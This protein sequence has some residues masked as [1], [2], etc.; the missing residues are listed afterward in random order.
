MRVGIEVGGTFTDLVAVDGESVR[1]AKVPS[2]PASPDEGA[3]Q[4]IDAAGIDPGAID[5][6]VHGSTV[7]TNAVLERKG[8]AVCLFVTKGIRD[9]LLLQRHDKDAIYDLRYAKPEPVVRR[10]DV[11]EIDERIAADGTVVASPD[12]AAVTRLVRRVLAEGSYE[13]AA[14]CFLHAYANPDHERMVAGVIREIAPSLPVTCSNEV[15]REFREYER[16]ST[17]ALAAYV[18]PVMAGYVN[19][20]SAA[21]GRRGFAGRFSIM[22]SNGGRM[23]AEAMARNAISALFSGPAAGVV[24]AVRSVADA[25]YRNLITLDMG[26]TSTDVALVAD[27]RT[28]ARVDDANRRPA[29][30]DP[31]R[32]H[33]HRRGRR[34]L[35]RVGRRRRP[36]QGRPGL[37]RRDAGTG[38][39]PARR[40]PADGDRCAP[41][42]RHP[43]AGC[44]PRRA[45]GGRPRC[46]SPGV[47]AIGRPVRSV[48]R[49]DRRQRDPPC[50]SQHR[51]RHPAGLHRTRPGPARLRAGALRRR[52]PAAR[53]ESGGRPGDR[54]RR[55]TAQRR[56]PFRFRSPALRPRSLS[57]PDPAAGRHRS[58]P[59][60]HPGDRRNVAGGSA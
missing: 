43:S 40:R 31:G 34:R 37:G 60:R 29:G 17:T 49:R 19:R 28:R 16:A 35:D 50:R 45:H 6:L 52:R 7:A 5:E 3:M 24:G 55:R 47:S 48:G 15:T 46:G 54:D 1:T 21:L 18:Q 27:G 13:A 53:G 2:T 51:A 56:C 38:L 23:P 20:F 14:L 26:G 30:E 4:A 12:R 10:R 32:R 36:A 22:Q 8:A 58:Q 9:V 33:R 11:V 41:R 25:G 39:L 42:P 57:N 44:V 59:V